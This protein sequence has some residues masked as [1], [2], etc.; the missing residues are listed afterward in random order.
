MDRGCRP[1]SASAT[2]VE[3]ASGIAIEVALGITVAIEVALGIASAP[4]FRSVMR[5]APNERGHL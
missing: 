5:T 1:A 4:I 2:L 3:I